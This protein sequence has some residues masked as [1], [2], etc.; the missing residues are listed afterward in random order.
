MTQEVDLEQALQRIRREALR[1]SQPLV[2]DDEEAAWERYK[3]QVRTTLAALVAALLAA[4]ITVREYERAMLELI[5]QSHTLA[6]AIAR[7]GLDLLDDADRAAITAR[8][9]GQAGFLR[10]WV[11]S[12]ALTGGVLLLAGR[13]VSEARMLARAEMYLEAA[14]ANLFAGAAARLGIDRLPAHPGDGTTRCRIYCHCS[15]RIEQLA[16]RD[17]DAYWLLGLAEHCEHCPRRAIAWSP[18][19]IRNGVLQPYLRIGLFL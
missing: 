15:W 2:S 17:F 16:E 4:R 1:N 18:L 3:A 19:Q 6:Y 12:L 14:K 11:A 9:N 10:A 7:G 13:P 5:R 8:V